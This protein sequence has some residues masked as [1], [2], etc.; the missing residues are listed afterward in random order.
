MYLHNLAK[1]VEESLPFI[2]VLSLIKMRSINMTSINEQAQHH[3]KRLGIK[4]LRPYERWDVKIPFLVIEGEFRELEGFMDYT[5]LRR[6]KRLS[7]NSLTFDSKKTYWDRVAEERGCTILKYDP[8]LRVNHPIQVKDRYGKLINTTFTTV[9]RSSYTQHGWSFGEHM[10]ASLLE[11]NGIKYTRQY[12]VNTAIGRQYVDFMVETTSSLVAIEY[13]G[14][15]HYEPIGYFSKPLSEQQRYDKAKADY[16]QAVNI[17]LVTIPYT[18]DNLYKVASYLTSLGVTFIPNKLSI[19]PNMELQLLKDYIDRGLTR[20]EVAD[21]YHV[22]TTKVS[23]TAKKYNRTHVPVNPRSKEI[24]T[25]EWAVLYDYIYLSKSRTETASIYDICPTT[26]TS[27]A[28]RNGFKKNSIGTIF[29][30]KSPQR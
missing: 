5:G 3:A 4:L 12:P 29:S 30:T 24:E 25:K 21:K 22:S 13:N 27:I 14:I 10:V 16:L 23:C 15:Q 1:R 18:A 6:A 8:K 19:V 20:K 11:A 26:V 7:Y 28:K 9:R 2:S 17:K